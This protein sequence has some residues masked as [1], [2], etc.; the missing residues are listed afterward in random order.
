[1]QSKSKENENENENFNSSEKLP[2]S[3]IKQ[4]ATILRPHI[5]RPVDSLFEQT[6]ALG[7]NRTQLPGKLDFAWNSHFVHSLS[8]LGGRSPGKLVLWH[9]GNMPGTTAAV[10]LL[11]ESNTAIV[12][13]QNSLGLCDIADWAAQAILDTILTGRP[14]HDYLELA[15]ESVKNGGRR[16]EDVQDRLDKERIPGTDHQPLKSYV[17]KYYNKIDN[18]VIEVCINSLGTLCLKFQAR[19]DEL[20]ILRHYH[21]DIFVC[22]LPYDE[23]VKRGQYCR[24]YTYYKF[25]FESKASNHSISEQSINC[26][27]WRHDTSV[28]EV[29]IFMKRD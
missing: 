10:C 7:W 6:Y 20:Y 17:G 22:N 16:M 11:P 3:P 4:I 5:A 14:A 12:V 26:L 27:R 23:L 13:L 24:P 19:D 2:V 1:M 9:G 28:S 25:E 29:E 15:R 21:H 8:L 18:W